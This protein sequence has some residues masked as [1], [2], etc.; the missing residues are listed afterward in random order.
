MLALAG[1]MTFLSV[2]LFLAG[3]IQIRRR[4]RLARRLL[5]DRDP[6]EQNAT[7]V[8]LPSI[9]DRLEKDARQAG[10]NWTRKTFLMVWVAGVGLGLVLW[11][12]GN[13]LGLLMGLGAVVVP[14]LVIRYRAKARTKVFATQLPT[15]LTL[16]ANVMRSGGSLYYAVG[17]VTRQMPE[18]IK[19]E[20]ARV[21]RAMQ[22]Q[23]APAEA[24]ARARDRIGVPEFGSV[25]VA[26]K[27]AG[28]AGADLDRVLESISR[29]LVEDAQFMKA[30]Q[31]ASA[32]GR[33]SAK[34]VTG[35]PFFVLGAIAFL[36][37]GYLRAAVSDP[38]G[39]MIMAL[40][41]GMILVGW[42]IIKRITDVRN[43]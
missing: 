12:S 25:V 13:E 20:F 34:L 11:L 32:E 43:W 42:V 28:E 33:A 41:F 8:K 39:L 27:V 36:S 35:V 16:M 2:A 7:A 9:L 10:L 17:A 6:L 4:S 18:P 29:E 26:C 22:L 21:E 23:V 14:S 30:M 19:S 1:L 37:P 5:S 3:L 38:S 31:A 24:M 15:A 40:G